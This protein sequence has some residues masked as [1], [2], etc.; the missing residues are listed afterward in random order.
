MQVGRP[1]KFDPDRALDRALKVFW[2]K[3]FDG[4]SLSDLTEA[5][6]IN[7]PS[8]YATFGDKEALFRRAMN[9]YVEVHACHVRAALDEPTVRKVVEK[10]WDGSIALSQ[11]PRNPRGCFLVQGAL[12]CGDAAQPLQ[13]AMSRQ[14][15]RGEAAL[16]TRF[17]TAIAEGELPPH[18]NAADLARYVSTVSYGLAV[19]AAGGATTADL[20]ATAAIALQALPDER[21]E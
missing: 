18:V 9:R 16:R 12:A 21:E 17:E 6:G 20:T 8:L 10:L 1:R 3:G 7:R 15:A 19:Q 4:T 11:N 13:Q 14:R 5:M 2:R